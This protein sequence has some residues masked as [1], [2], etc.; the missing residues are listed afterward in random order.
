M[1]L[2]WVLAG[3]ACVG[4]LFFGC[5]ELSQ[6]AGTNTNWLE[7]CRSDAE[8]SVGSCL[9]GLCTKTCENAGDCNEIEAAECRSGEALGCTK[10]EPVCA[11][12]S[13]AP[14]GSGGSAGAPGASAGSQ[15]T[16]AGAGANGGASGG[17]SG[18]ASCERFDDDTSWSVS[19]NVRNATDRT[20]HVG[21]DE[22]T[23]GLPPL[24]TVEDEQ[25]TLLQDPG[26]CRS[27]CEDRGLIGGCPPVCLWPSSLT[28]E[29]GEGV[30]LSWHG[31]YRVDTELPLECVAEEVGST[32]PVPCDQARHIEPGQFTFRARAGTELDCS[33][34]IRD[35]C[36][37]CTANPD[38]GG[39]C[40]RLAGL[41]S[42][43]LLEATVTVDLDASYGVGATEPTSETG[44][45]N[46]VELVFSD[47]D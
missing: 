27:R 8:C 12:K 25:G 44:E 38:A 35:E 2:R 14:G 6:P 7:R 3:S 29:P 4:G 39:G 15:S 30:T 40:T 9:C 1:K 46:P 18:S 23:C 10:P 11:P 31:L 20:I 5:G 24:F 43:E 45:L 47:S 22:V 36:P 41:I 19:V 37:A 13:S 33:E 32:V 26:N 34:T 17:G 28:L 42:G 21:T 16:S